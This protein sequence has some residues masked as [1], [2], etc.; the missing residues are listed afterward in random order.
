MTHADAVNEQFREEAKR[1]LILHSPWVIV[2]VNYQLDLNKY[3]VYRK[4]LGD[5]VM[6]IKAPDVEDK[7]RQEIAEWAM[8]ELDK[9]MASIIKKD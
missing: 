7:T 2:G 9:Y 3:D 1:L 6:A 8:S 4:E 5:K